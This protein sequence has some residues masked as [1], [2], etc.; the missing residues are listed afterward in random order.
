MSLLKDK[1]AVVIGASRGIG[2]GIAVG[3]GREGARV[4]VAARTKERGEKSKL[5]AEGYVVSGSLAET[6]AQIRDAGGEA[7]TFPCDAQ[8]TEQIHALVEETIERYGRLDILVTSLQPD[9][10]VEGAFCDLPVSAWDGHM[11]VVPRAFYVAA[12]AAAPHMT[13]QGSGL[14][15]T[16]SSPGGA[17]DFYSVPYCVARAAADR[18]AQA[19][20]HELGSSGVA[21][22]SL[23]PTYMRTD[24][25]RRAQAGEPQGFSIDGSLD[26]ETEADAP[27]LLGAAIARLSLDPEL[28]TLSGK[29][30][31][32]NYLAKRYG[33]MDENGSDPAPVPFLDELIAKTGSL[34]PSA[35]HVET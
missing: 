23:W 8:D 16:V 25:V 26:L 30:Q 6:A 17:F 10:A 34:A 2:R 20:D 18:L 35:Y 31:V 5:G 1:V 9:G 11:A 33:L 28:S 27:E 22:V 3:L 29:V 21:A 14:L 12:R 24:R 32:L 7:T 13:R 15:A 19:L 4:V